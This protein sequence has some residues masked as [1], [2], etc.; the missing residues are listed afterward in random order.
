MATS[1]SVQRHVREA[2]TDAA[3]LPGY[4]SDYSTN[5]LSRWLWAMDSS[6]AL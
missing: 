3:S 1:S 2:G 6:D 5:A 4:I